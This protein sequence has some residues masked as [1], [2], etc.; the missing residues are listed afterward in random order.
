MVN[1]VDEAIANAMHISS[2]EVPETISEFD[3]AG[4]NEAPCT[5]VKHP[6][7]AESPVSF[8]CRLY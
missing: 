4:L 5:V 2:E 1:L 7:V 8:E 6:R 3:T